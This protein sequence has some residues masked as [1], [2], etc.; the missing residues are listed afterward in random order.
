MG[1]SQAF[2]LARRT[3]HPLHVRVQ[4]PRPRRRPLH[5]KD[6][7]NRA[8][9][10]HPQHPTTHHRHAPARGQRTELGPRPKASSSTETLTNTR[11]QSADEKSVRSS[12]LDREPP[13][14]L[15]VP[16]TLLITAGITCIRVST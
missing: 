1:L 4:R 2:V 12:F 3:A 11:K 9:R 5:H 6:P 13:R 16:A 8:S 10:H 15:S 7:R 14:P